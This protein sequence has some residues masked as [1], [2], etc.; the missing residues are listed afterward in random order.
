MKR[1]NVRP[2]KKRAYRISL[3]Y[4]IALGCIELFVFHLCFWDFTLT[5][6]DTS[7][8]SLNKT[9]K[10]AY[11]GQFDLEKM[12]MQDIVWMHSKSSYKA[13]LFA[14]LLNATTNHH[15]SN[16]LAAEMDSDA[17]MSVE[18]TVQVLAHLGISRSTIEEEDVKQLPPWSQIVSNYGSEPIIYGLERCQAYRETVPI[19]KRMVGPAGLFSTG[20]NVLHRLLINNCSPPPEIREK[21]FFPWQVPW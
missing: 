12:D 16:K 19:E 13:A 9:K 7:E 6:V 3:N 14:P 2:R 1:G 17:E 11:T 10:E 18:K 5:L 20:T 15:K 21:K 4:V 8:P